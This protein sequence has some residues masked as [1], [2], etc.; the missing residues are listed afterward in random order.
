MIIVKQKFNPM[1]RVIQ[2]ELNYYA[3]Q[4]AIDEYIRENSQPTYFQGQ[5]V[6][7]LQVTGQS[8][9]HAAGLADYLNQQSDVPYEFNAV[10]GYFSDYNLG[11]HFWIV[12]EQLLI[13]LAIKQFANYPQLPGDLLADLTQHCYL[14]CDNPDD[15][16]HRLYIEEVE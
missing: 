9:E 3:L 14:I 1:I 12:S 11:Q 2:P 6:D 4:E 10:R 13:D 7:A 15:P 8:Q 5:L 16:I